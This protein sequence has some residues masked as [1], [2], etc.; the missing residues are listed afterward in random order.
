MSDV[1]W[2]S[3]GLYGEENFNF[4]S[5]SLPV[6]KLHSAVYL[7]NRQVRRPLMSWKVVVFLL[8]RIEI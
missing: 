1:L 5:I 8:A 7:G 6:S 4:S 3:L 2:R